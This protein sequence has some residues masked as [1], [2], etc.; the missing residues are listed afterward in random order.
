MKRV[1]LNIRLLLV[2]VIFLAG[3]L[4][5]RYRF[6]RIHTFSYYKSM[7]Q[8]VELAQDWFDIIGEEKQRREIISDAGSGVPNGFMIGDDFTSITTTLGSL[9]AKEVSSNP[10]FAALMVRLLK[11]AGMEPGNKAGLIISGSFPA[12]AVSTLAA[13]RVLDMEAVIMSSLGAST[14]GANQE[15]ATWI[16]METWLE[17]HPDF[18]FSSLLVSYGAENDRGEGMTEEGRDNIRKAAARNDRQLYIPASLMESIRYKTE[19]LSEE[20]I[21]I[22]INIGGNQ[23]ALGGCSH[24]SAMPNGLQHHI[25]LCRDPD[26][27]ILQEMNEMGVPVINL[28]NIRDLASVYGIDLSPGNDYAEST[29]LFADHKPDRIAVMISLIIGFLCLIILLDIRIRK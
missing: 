15:E 13:I 25:R 20:N 1:P 21:D 19:I 23:S 4:L 14:F 26:R 11:T 28:L 18:S 5:T 12:L 29:N 2:F 24:A 10:D 8:A 27:G 22:L 7:I 6:N 9:S 3:F 16:D 17:H